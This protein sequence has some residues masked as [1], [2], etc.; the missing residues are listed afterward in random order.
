MYID[1]R[2]QEHN[3]LQAIA[4]VNR[5][6]NG[7]KRGYIGLANHLTQA[8]SIY[9]RE[10]AQD[11]QMGLKNVLSELP[12][13]EERYQR[14]LQHFLSLGISQIEQFVQGDL[15]AEEEA[16]VIHAAVRGLQDPKERGEFEVFLK[17]FLE[18]LNLILP[19]S[20]G[21]SY[22]VPARRFSYLLRMTKERYK[23][24]SLDISDAGE[25]VS[26]LVNEYLIDLGID[27]QNPAD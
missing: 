11:I 3:L 9:S 15:S 14:L 25:K 18:S 17:K 26:K 6:A 20:E 2:L 24:D 21:Q 4:R 16:Q 7:K 5:I 10:D 8:L 22:R 12:I 27:P 23:D 1:R 13:L 19:N